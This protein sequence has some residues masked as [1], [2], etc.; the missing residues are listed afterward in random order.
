MNQTRIPKKL[1]DHGGDIYQ[2]GPMPVLRD[3]SAS[4]NPLGHPEGLLEAIA[5]SWGEI[6]NYPDRRSAAL[7]DAIFKR[8]GVDP[9]TLMAGNGS[10]ELID[11]MLRASGMKRLIMTPPDFGLYTKFVPGDVEIQA[12]PRIEAAGFR[13]DLE[14]L[15][16][17]MRSG[18]LL[19]F[20]NPGNPS[21]ATLER[22]EV[23][24]LARMAAEREALIVVDEAFCDFC[25][26]KSVLGLAASQPQLVV[27]RSLTKFFGIPG[28]RLGFLAA[29]APLLERMED[30]R[31]PW[32]VSTIA[33]SAGIHCLKDDNWGEKSR[34]YARRAREKF[35]ND[36]AALPGMTPLP[37]E[38][39]YLL[40]RLDPPA[41]D[42]DL[43]YERLKSEGTLIR[44][45]TS[46]GLGNRYVRL[47]V[48][49]VGEN[50]DLIRHMKA[51]YR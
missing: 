8:Y 34:Q 49:T 23:L 45:C 31:Q 18:D 5:E 6:L 24:L 2:K 13:V 14:G 47:A 30:L 19:L 22:E 17:T 15:A 11:L 42:A 38:A 33:Q 32:S 46:F 3:F 48:R 12:V 50:A 36:L 4:I 7:L 40:L 44:H 26:E 25:P 20:S 9:G 21:G 37:S 43:L 10:A 35:A 39:N 41:P 1:Q 28:L 51:F 16:K 27:M 29:A